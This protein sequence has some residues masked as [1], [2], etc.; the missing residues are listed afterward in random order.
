MHKMQEKVKS[1]N[2]ALK[3]AKVDGYLAFENGEAT[4]DDLQRE[5]KVDVPTARRW[6]E[7]G[8]RKVWDIR[9]TENYDM[10]LT[11]PA[12]IFFAAPYKKGRQYGTIHGVYIAHAYQNNPDGI[13][14]H[15]PYN[16]EQIIKAQLSFRNPKLEII[17]IR[18][19]LW[20]RVQF[21]SRRK[22]KHLLAGAIISDAINPKELK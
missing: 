12:V 16:A 1:I 10:A 20:D 19:S 15:A 4:F 11:A 22:H 17:A 14:A 13:G 6:L 18:I 21:Y 9:H 8:K 7:A 2:A 5:W 3:R